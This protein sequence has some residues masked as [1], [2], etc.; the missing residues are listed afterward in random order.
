MTTNVTVTTNGNTRHME[1]Q[2]PK[3]LELTNYKPQKPHELPQ[4]PG[5]VRVFVNGGKPAISR[6]T[7]PY[8]PDTK[9]FKPEY[10]TNLSSLDVDEMTYYVLDKIINQADDWNGKK[11]LSEEDLRLA[12]KYQL[13]GVK[14]VKSVTRV[15]ATGVTTVYLE[16]GDILRFDV[17]SNEEKATRIKKERK[18]NAV[19]AQNEAKKKASEQQKEPSYSDFVNKYG[20]IRGSMEWFRH[21]TGLQW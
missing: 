20:V 9:D 6:M 14:G 10:K 15:D 18:A 21:T 19:A 13:K 2:L 17:E 7:R 8:P 16:N 12:H 4:K 11:I 3:R 1:V 5:D